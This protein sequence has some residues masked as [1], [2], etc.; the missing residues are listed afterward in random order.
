MVPTVL[1]PKVQ[2]DPGCLPCTAMHDVTTVCIAGG[3][4]AVE[5]HALH[6]SMLH[7]PYVLERVSANG[8]TF[9]SVRRPDIRRSSKPAA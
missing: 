1:Q 7:L 9:E 5:Q 8:D 6:M 3:K 4:A 2:V